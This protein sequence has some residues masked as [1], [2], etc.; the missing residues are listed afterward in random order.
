MDINSAI[1]TARQMENHFRAFS[2]LREILEY[3]STQMRDDIE[4]EK[5]ITQRVDDVKEANAKLDVLNVKLESRHKELEALDKKLS[6]Y[7]SFIN[8]EMRALDSELETY[9]FDFDNSILKM[10]DKYAKTE[11]LLRD[12]I[13]KMEA[14]RLAK[15]GEVEEVNNKLRELKESITL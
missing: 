6:D 3:I 8:G 14:E 9:I 10:K 12:T 4:Y 2:Q 13:D 5:L 1:S 15:L 7:A 11:N